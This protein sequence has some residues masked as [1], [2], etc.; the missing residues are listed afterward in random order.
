MSLTSLTY[1]MREDITDRDKQELLE[2]GIRVIGSGKNAYITEDIESYDTALHYLYKTMNEDDENKLVSMN[3]VLFKQ[4]CVQAK[5]SSEQPY[6]MTITPL[7]ENEI[8]LNNNQHPKPKKEIVEKLLSRIK[9]RTI[10]GENRVVKLT[11]CEAFFYLL[12]HIPRGR[13]ENRVSIN[14]KETRLI[15]TY[16][17]G[18]RIVGS[19][20]KIIDKLRRNTMPVEIKTEYNFL[21]DKEHHEKICREYE[22]LIKN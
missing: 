3:N 2:N 15:F 19:G 16:D 8:D 5:K 6:T 1:G 22:N 11:R 17:H 4:L 18:N 20:G 21:D 13:T 9:N 14:D 7:D 10:D 12:S